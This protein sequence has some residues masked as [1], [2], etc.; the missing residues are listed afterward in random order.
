[1]DDMVERFRRL[2]T[3]NICDARGPGG[4]MISAIRPVCH[5]MRLAGR[6]YTVKIPAGD[7]LGLHR[8][9]YNA[10]AGS[11]LVVDAEG[12]AGGGVFGDIMATA[13]QARGISGVVIDGACRDAV[14]LAELG[15]AVF[16]GA[17]NPGGTVKE[18]PGELNQTITCGGVVVHPGD[19]VVGDLD[20]VVVVP[21]ETAQS[22]LEKA[23]QKNRDEGMVRRRLLAGESTLTIFGLEGK[24]KGGEAAT[25]A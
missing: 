14:D 20:G 3:G 9:I 16:S 25:K 8:A 19:V 5:K 15:F 23:E 17:V 18:N 7:N 1:M 13:C 24:L 21:A 2:P 6:A 4:N 22:V 10:P 11:V 12:Y